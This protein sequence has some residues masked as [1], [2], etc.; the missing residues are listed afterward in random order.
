M[1]RSRVAPLAKLTIPR[2]ELLSAL[3]LARLLTTVKASF[4]PIFDVKIMRCWTDS[5]TTLYWIHGDE[6]EWKLFVENR[7]MEIRKLISKDL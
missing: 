6:R 7:M 2:L 4:D 5:I 3:T 1:S